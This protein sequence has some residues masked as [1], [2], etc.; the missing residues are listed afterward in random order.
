MRKLVVVAAVAV[1]VLLGSPVAVSA[2]PQVLRAGDLSVAPGGAPKTTLVLF[3]AGR[4][5]PDFA[6]VVDL[7]P[8]DG[9]VEVTAPDPER[10]VTCTAT[11]TTLTC[12]GLRPANTAGVHLRVVA[13][14]GAAVGAVAALPVRLTDAGRTIAADTLHVTVAE[15]VDLA[16]VPIGAL[17][18]QRVGDTLTVPLGVRNV[19][20]TPVTGV[21]ALINK[22]PVLHPPQ[23]RNCWYG[24]YDEGSMACEFDVTLAPGSE[25]GTTLDLRLSTQVWAPSEHSGSVT[26]LTRHDWSE[27]RSTFARPGTRGTGG[28]LT[29]RE[30][31]ARQA[32]PQTDVDPDDNYTLMAFRV[33]GVNRANFTAYGDSVTGTVG[34]TVRVR[35][36]LR[37][38]GPARLDSPYTSGY[39]RLINAIRFPAGV[40]VVAVP[41]GCRLV[42][43]NDP[44]PIPPGARPADGEY[45]CWRSQVYLPGVRQNFDFTVRLDRAL[46]RATGEVYTRL[47]N[48]EPPDS[49]GDDD[50]S[51]DVRPIVIT[52]RVATAGPG[53]D[54]GGGTGGGASLPITGDSTGPV[55]LAGLLLVLLGGVLTASASFRRTKT[56][57]GS[58]RRGGVPDN[59][60]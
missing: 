7:R 19:G 50:P 30:V 37:N 4:T 15:G 40:T 28:A 23:Y 14:P 55:A 17:G 46:D 43:D 10:D 52:A 51:D 26:W 44:S 8:A 25:Y 27:W 32:L 47:E 20:A 21:V 11:A 13:R 12:A 34:R 31:V 16:A 22:G 41:P 58:F 24:V 48:W 9:I 39:S 42:L 3:S 29:L 57:I 49:D 56:A 36:G 1:T 53:G 54:S 60:G 35:V 18:D 38:N 5:L 45:T 33:G 2:A 6:F 59:G